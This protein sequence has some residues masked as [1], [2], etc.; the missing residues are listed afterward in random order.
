MERQ[1]KYAVVG[2]VIRNRIDEHGVL[3][4]GTKEFPAGAK[5]YLYGKFWNETFKNISAI[6]LDRHK[7]YRVVDLPVEYIENL[8]IQKV[9]KLS[10]LRIMNDFEFEQGWWDNSLEEKNNAEY[11]IKKWNNKEN[12]PVEQ[13]NAFKNRIIEILRNNIF[14]EGRIERFMNYYYHE[15]IDSFRE[16]KNPEDLI[17]QILKVL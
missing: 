5:L 9:Y 12:F 4:H 11:F 1:W 14:D 13:Y 3:R 15:I 10:V 17:S 7:R 6:G 8:R 2:N 16:G